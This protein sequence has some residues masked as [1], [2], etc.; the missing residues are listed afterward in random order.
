MPKTHKFLL[1][2]TLEEFTS[3]PQ[4]PQMD[5]RG[6]FEAG[7]GCGKGTGEQGEGRERNGRY[8]HPASYWYSLPDFLHKHNLHTLTLNPN[9]NP[10]P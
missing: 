10:K 5:L 6:H 4:A 8:L 9:P 7:N 1:H 3:L 2:R